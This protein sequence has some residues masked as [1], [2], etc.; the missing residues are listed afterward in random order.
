AAGYRQFEPGGPA[1]QLELP[2]GAPTLAPTSQRHPPP[3][4][5]MVGGVIVDRGEDPGRQLVPRQ[6]GEPEAWR[7]LELEFA[8]EEC[9]HVVQVSRSGVRGPVADRCPLDPTASWRHTSGFV[10]RI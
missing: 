8:L 9:L 10:D 5:T 1:R 2:A 3:R 7:S 6:V 4:E